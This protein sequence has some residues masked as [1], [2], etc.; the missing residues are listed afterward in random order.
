[1]E[2]IDAALVNYAAG[3]PRCISSHLHR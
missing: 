3:K 2:G 1:M